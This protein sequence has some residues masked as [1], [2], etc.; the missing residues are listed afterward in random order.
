M[1]FQ[2]SAKAEHSLLLTSYT[3]RMAAAAKTPLRRDAQ[4]NRERIIAA[5]RE[6]FGERGLDVGVDEIARRA[7][8]GM[9][10]LYRHFPTKDALIDAVVEARFDELVASAEAALQADDA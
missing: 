9:G 3:G 1:P 10:T 5:T 4:R 7:G 8:V 6:A 2:G